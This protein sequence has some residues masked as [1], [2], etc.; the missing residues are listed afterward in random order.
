MHCTI[1]TI[2]TLMVKVQKVQKVQSKFLYYRHLM[3]GKRRKKKYVLWS[4]ADSNRSPQHCQCCAL[5]R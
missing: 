1:C 5:A 2:C 4:I 3:P